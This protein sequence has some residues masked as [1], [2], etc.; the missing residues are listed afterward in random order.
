[1]KN[2][3]G[4]VAL[5][6]TAIAAATLAAT[7]A[8]GG[9]PKKKGTT[10]GAAD[11]PPA[12]QPRKIEREVTRKAEED[13]AKVVEAYQKQEKAGWTRDACESMAAEFEEV[14]EHH[15]KL[16]EARF[17]AGLSYQNCGITER[18]EEQYKTALKL[19]P[20]HAPSLSNLG[21]IYFD[22][23]NEALA[24][25]YWEK[26]VSADRKIVAARNNLAWLAIREIRASGGKTL[27]SQEEGVKRH[28]RS[29][30]AVDNDNVEAYVL[31]ALLYMEGSDRNKSRLTLAR[32]LL[33]KGAEIEDKFAPLH[34]AR[35]LLE[36]RNDNVPKALA[37]FRRAVE[38]DPDFVEARMNVGNIVL[39]FRK[40]AE[41]KEQ[42]DA[43]LALRPK[44]YDAMIGLGYAQRG[45]KDLDGAE[46][47]YQA[48]KKLDSTR[49]EA[50]FNLGVLY[51]DFRATG[52]EDLREAQK[53]Y[54]TA[55][56]HFKQASSKAD[57]RSLQKEASENIKDCEK[58][59][60]SLEENIKFREQM[61]EG[62]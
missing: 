20:G 13:F 40:Y 45:L 35:G 4:I 59:V 31:L 29:A 14:A 43:V 25:Q 34:N 12:G 47:S 11:A 56:V 52:T 50:D 61:Q 44:D 49:P 54:R 42:F 30:L 51:K 21:Q 58:N 27:K 57:N 32:L 60:D 17:N 7:V 16:I 28:L 18:A 38:L 24:K 23:E 36:L 5:L 9:S 1:M 37:S 8:C 53:A 26:A 19:N 10:V 62:S 22:Q 2:R 33:D 46:Q 15:P 41:A 48:A 39:G 3:L 55:A 6:K